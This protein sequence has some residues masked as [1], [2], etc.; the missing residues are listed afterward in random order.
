MS[1][2]VMAGTDRSRVERVKAW[3]RLP[4]PIAH[5]LVPPRRRG[6]VWV[7]VTCRVCS[8]TAMVVS[9]G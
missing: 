5:L 6:A 9:W 3:L 1:A 4:I 2:S 8:G 7:Q